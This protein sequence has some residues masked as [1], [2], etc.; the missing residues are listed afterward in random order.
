VGEAV[1]L[2]A[3]LERF[4]STVSGMI[5]LDAAEDHLEASAGR[6]T[7]RLRRLDGAWV[8]RSWPAAEVVSLSAADR[9]GLAKVAHAAG[10][11]R[12]APILGGIR[13]GGGWAVA[14]DGYR[15]AKAAIDPAIPVC[16]PSAQVVMRLVTD[17]DDGPIALGSTGAEVLLMTD[18]VAWRS[19]SI[20]GAYFDWERLIPPEADTP[21]RLSADREGLLEAVRRVEKV[22]FSNSGADFTR[23][24]L[25]H[26]PGGGVVVGAHDSEV[27]DVSAEVD[28]ELTVSPIAFNASYLREALEHTEGA[29][30]RARFAGAT[31]PLVIEDAGSLQLVMPLRA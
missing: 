26:G 30:V 1:V 17:A 9:T 15:L 7:V 14:S 24:V 16:L 31:R 13:L 22:G 8:D 11:S 4:V 6:S 18:E 27:G 12:Q 23:L 19:P 2:A 28:G 10:N 29:V 5:R 25:E 21:E 3:Y 20:E